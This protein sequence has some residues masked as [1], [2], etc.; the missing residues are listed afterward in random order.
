[1]ELSTIFGVFGVIANSSWPLI[2]HRKYLLS[3]QALACVLMFAHFWLLGAQTGALV[4]AAAGIQACLAIPLES[5]PRFKSVYFISLILTP[6]VA[7]F[8]WHGLPS[9]FSTFALVF[10]C[11]GNLQINTKHL[12]ILLLCCLFCWVVHNLL[13]SSYPALASN[14]IALCTSIYGLSREFMPNKS[15]QQDAQKAR[16]SA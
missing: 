2:K 5:H 10:F 16:A 6:L 14:F 3:G 12:R 7:W 15:S 1:M 8:S 9:I 4:M 13:I 11:I